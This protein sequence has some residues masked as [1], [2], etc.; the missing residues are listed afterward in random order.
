MKSAFGIRRKKATNAS[1]PKSLNGPGSW[2]TE[3]PVRK[4]RAKSSWR[5]KERWK[6]QP[7][8]AS[9]RQRRRSLTPRKLVTQLARLCAGHSSLLEARRSG[10][11]YHRSRR[12]FLRRYLG[13][14]GNQ[15]AQ[16]RNKHD[17]RDAN[18]EAARAERAEELHIFRV[19][20]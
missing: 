19:G 13:L 12:H 9:N 5:S 1:S 14:V 3:P 18:H 10:D 16:E 2:R 8:K 7:N 6:S 4:Q 15:L 17:E 20:R 11:R